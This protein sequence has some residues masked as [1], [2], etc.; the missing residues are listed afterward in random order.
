MY[1]VCTMSRVAGSM[2]TGPR[3]LFHDCPF[4]AST[5]FGPSLLPLV[6]FSAA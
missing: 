2:V 6:F 3:T 1:T 5:S 4:I